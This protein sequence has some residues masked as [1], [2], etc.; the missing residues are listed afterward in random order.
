MVKNKRYL[1]QLWRKRDESG[2][3][4][5][6][7]AGAMLV[8][9]GMIGLAVDLGVIYVR[10]AQ[11]RAAVDAAALA[12]APE[13]SDLGI[14]GADE[15][16]RQFLFVNGVPSDTALN[17]DSSDGQTE[18][19]SFQYTVTATWTIDLYFMTLFSFETFDL[20]KAATAAYF[21]VTDIYASSRVSDGALTTVNQSIYGPNI[22]TD[23]GDP[24]SPINST[25][26]PGPYSY[27]YRIY[28]PAD[29][30]TTTVRV[31]LFDPDSINNSSN[32]GTM[33]HTD[34]WLTATGSLS[35][36]APIACTLYPDSLQN[37]T[38]IVPTCEWDGDT[39]T[40]YRNA[41]G[42]GATVAGG[43]EDENA[44]N[45]FWYFRVDEN[46][47]GG[48]APGDGS[49][50]SRNG[51]Y[52]E[53]FNTATTFELYYFRELPDGS[54]IRTPLA[55]YTGQTGHYNA[56]PDSFSGHRRL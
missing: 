15:K 16:A 36:T 19:G 1:Q 53:S 48:T 40:D 34:Y 31:E 8:L 55:S 20:T 28:I 11:L 12:G 30:I 52:D 29:Y 45:P 2:Q 44:V 23:F 47:G 56:D 38:C 7:I 21:P 49:C 51:N 41:C 50:V 17:F 35:A 13:L 5:V 6:I 46:A 43:Q 3:S 33:I 42:D 54:L 26:A 18:L 9:L 14:A 10:D 4:I 25:Y 32:S 27:R 22:C 37:R 39:S 24:F